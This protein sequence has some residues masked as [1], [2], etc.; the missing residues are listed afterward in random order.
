MARY[1]SV[2]CRQKLPLH[3]DEVGACAGR[4]L[5][6]AFRIVA[7]AQC[8]AQSC[9][10]QLRGDEVALDMLLLGSRHGGIEFDQHVAR[11]DAL[12]VANVNG[13]YDAGFERLDQL[14]AA[15]GHDLAR[16][17]TRQYRHGRKPPRSAPDRRAQ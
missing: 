11:F 10:V 16:M 12:A 5:K 1:S 6:R 17:Q 4:R 8:R 2:C 3:G 7:V 9:N 13:A 14:D 15:A